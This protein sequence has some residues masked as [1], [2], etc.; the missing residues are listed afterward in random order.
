MT[1]RL[2]TLAM[3]LLLAACS[4]LGDLGDILG[5]STPD[6]SSDV[7]GVVERVDTGNRQ[8]VLN[9]NYVNN[10]R[11]DRSGSVIY[12]DNNTVVLYSGNQYRVEDLE[13]GDEISV[14]GSNQGGR[15]VASRIT[16]TRNVRG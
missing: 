9:V 15:Y 16:V 13:R 10:L 2:S 14:Q 7:R 3:V 1:K 8:I 5:S 4:N 6:Q 11:D 12:Y